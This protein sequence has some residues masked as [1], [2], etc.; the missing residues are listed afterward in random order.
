M[1]KNIA[2]LGSTGS[3]GKNLLDLIYK[4][5]KKFK[6][7]LLTSNKN[8]QDLYKQSK[9]FNVRNL[10][11]TD[12]NSFKALKRKNKNK[13][14]KIFSNFKSFNKIFKKKLIM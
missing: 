3:I 13:K 8:Y 1:K 11:V 6:I 12:K 14:V 9:K 10:I 5:K 7:I 2:I 4:D